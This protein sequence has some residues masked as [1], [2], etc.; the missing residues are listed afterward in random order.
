MMLS[1]VRLA[2]DVRAVAAIE[3]AF[4]APV[5]VLMICGFM[6]FSHVSSART[7]L[8]GATMRAARAVAASDCP[9]ER[10]GLMTN[11]IEQAMLDIPSPN[12]GVVEVITKSYSDKFGDVGEPEPFND[13]NTNMIWDVGE[14]FTD[15]NGNGAYDKDM[16][17]A[18]SIGGAGQVVSYTA[19]YQVESLFGFVSQ[20]FKGANVYSIEASTVI[21]N[22]PIFNTTGC[23]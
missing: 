1:I 6:E 12:G 18:G 16:G 8:E 20:Q 21:R 15:V 23:T 10:Q 4:I 2:K 17:S 3:F 13:Q 22:E 9:S 11:I 19:R 5:M 7:R 14:S